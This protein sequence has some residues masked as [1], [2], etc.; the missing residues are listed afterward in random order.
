MLLLELLVLHAEVSLHL[1]N[2]SPTQISSLRP[3]AEPWKGGQSKNLTTKC[4]RLNLFWTWLVVKEG[5]EGAGQYNSSTSFKILAIQFIILNGSKNVRSL[6]WSALTLLL[7]F[8]KIT[9]IAQLLGTLPPDSPSVVH[10]SGTS[11]EKKVNF[12]FRPPLFSKI[13]VERLAS[14]DAMRWPKLKKIILGALHSNRNNKLAPKSW[15]WVPV[16]F[17]YFFGQNSLLAWSTKQE[18]VFMF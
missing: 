8:R 16:D 5:A 7:F 3:V 17:Y 12:G 2:F 18:Q 13:L 4:K 10:W 9:K 15:L 1:Y 11:L 6:I 14:A